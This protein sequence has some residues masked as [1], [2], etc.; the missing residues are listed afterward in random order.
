VNTFPLYVAQEV[1]I[2]ETV[3]KCR[4][5]AQTVF[6][7]YSAKMES[8]DAF[9]VLAYTGTLAAAFIQSERI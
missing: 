3:T 9:T 8:P 2:S 7:K 5:Y 1:F 4:V 6:M